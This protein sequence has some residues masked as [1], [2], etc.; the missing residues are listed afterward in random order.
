ME[1]WLLQFYLLMFYY[2]LVYSSRGL[3]PNDETKC[4]VERRYIKEELKHGYSMRSKPLLLTT[5]NEEETDD[6]TMNKHGQ[7]IRRRRL[8]GSL[9]RVPIGKTIQTMSNYR[10]T[11]DYRYVVNPGKK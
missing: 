7:W 6:S 8:D 2:Y 11:L 1:R 9:N 5:E 4:D 3:P 10:I